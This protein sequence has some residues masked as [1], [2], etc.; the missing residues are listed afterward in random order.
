VQR[1][2][3]I[4]LRG[5]WRRRAWIAIGAVLVDDGPDLIVLYVPEGAPF[6][7]APVAPIPHPWEGRAGWE[8]HGVL[9]LHRPGD[10]YAVWVF[11]QGP[12][13]EFS[14]WYVNLQ[15]PLTRSRIG[16]DMLDHEL[17]LWSTDGQTWHWKD[18]ELLEQRVREGLF[19]PAEAEAIRTEGARVHLELSERGPW[20]DDA[21]ARWT[22]DPEWA[23]PVL[24]RD[25]QRVEPFSEAERL[26][27][28]V[29]P[30]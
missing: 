27:Y 6:G 16:F 11:W 23:L 10:N 12:E 18:A 14:T 7:F 5:V 8:G 22:P 4:V 15:T 26:A 29:R 17:D 20:W 28:G 21:W 1:G 3:A 24:P 30:R 19:T 9:V 25:W 2:D 13:R